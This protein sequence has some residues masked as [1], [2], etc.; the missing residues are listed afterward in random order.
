MNLP[1]VIGGYLLLTFARR[2]M[3]SPADLYGH[4]MNAIKQIVVEVD[5]ILAG[6]LTDGLPILIQANGYSGVQ[7]RED[8][9][10]AGEG[11]YLAQSGM[12][13]RDHSDVNQLAQTVYCIYEAKKYAERVSSVGQVTYLAIARKNNDVRMLG[14]VGETYL[15]NYSMVLDQNHLGAL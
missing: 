7:I 1:N 10:V 4:D 6:F 14:T 5:C 15:I 9:A 13:H 3:I 11:A 12:L 8:F 2:E